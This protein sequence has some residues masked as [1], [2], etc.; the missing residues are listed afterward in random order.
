MLALCRSLDGHIVTLPAHKQV[1]GATAVDIH[2]G[3]V[4]GFFRRLP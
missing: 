3:V 1:E 4:A 2:I